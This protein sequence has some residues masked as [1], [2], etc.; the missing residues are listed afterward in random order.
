M[1]RIAEYNNNYVKTTKNDYVIVNTE[2]NLVYDASTNNQF[3]LLYVNGINNVEN[4]KYGDLLYVALND[5]NIDTSNPTIAYNLGAADE[6]KKLQV[7][8]LNTI[9][10]NIMQN[11][12]NIINNT[13][14][15]YEYMY[16][17][18]PDPLDYNNNS[19]DNSSYGYGKVILKTEPFCFAVDNWYGGAGQGCGYPGCRSIQDNDNNLYAGHGSSG[20]SLFQANNNPPPTATDVPIGTINAPPESF[21]SSEKT[22]NVYFNNATHGFTIILDDTDNYSLKLS[23][24]SENKI[25]VINEEFENS[26]K[27]FSA[28]IYPY[29]STGTKIQSAGKI[30]YITTIG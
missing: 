3:V 8:S 24:A 7:S 25:N 17:I 4:I 18:N 23:T 2:S 14:S 9:Q 11:M 28:T 12:E 10:Q 30:F 20:V 16:Y 13:S 1:N 6:N 21:G 27:T 19:Q 15:I 29:N 5:A 26:G 22:L